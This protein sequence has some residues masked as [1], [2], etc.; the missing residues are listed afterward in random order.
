MAALVFEPVPGAV[1]ALESL[2]ARG[3]PLGLVANWDP[4]LRGQ[5]RLHGLDGYFAAVVISAEVGAAKPDP[6]PFLAAL[7]L[8]GAAPERTVHVG[9]SAADEQGALAA[10]LRFAWAPLAEAVEQ[11]A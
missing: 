10:G 4:S 8:L 6:K 11:W 2:A 3:L 1:Q 9:D 5:L 7:E